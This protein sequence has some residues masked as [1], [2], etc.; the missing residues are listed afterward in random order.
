MS[1]IYIY[2]YI[3]ISYSNALYNF[4]SFFSASAMS[5]SLA[6][7]LS[8]QGKQPAWSNMGDFPIRSKKSLKISYLWVLLQ[9]TCTYLTQLIRMLMLRNTRNNL[10]SYICNHYNIYPSCSLMTKKFKQF[11][12]ILYSIVRVFSIFY[13]IYKC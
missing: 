13:T 11:K 2:A 1:Y 6:T 12:D 8:S 7:Q 5:L 10:F 3:Y 4:C 9:I